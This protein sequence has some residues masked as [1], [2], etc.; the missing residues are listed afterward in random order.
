MA[1]PTKP[2]QVL[3]PTGK[4]GFQKGHSG[5]DNGAQKSAG[6]RI[7]QALGAAALEEDAARVKQLVE[8]IWDEAIKGRQEWAVKLLMTRLCGPDGTLDS[9]LGENRVISRIEFVVVDPIVDAGSGN[10]EITTTYTSQ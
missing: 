2:G 6:K 8:V 9:L 10:S 3:N 5:F 4:G 1:W 7:L